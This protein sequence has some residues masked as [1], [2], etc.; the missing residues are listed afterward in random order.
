MGTISS[1]ASGRGSVDAADS[2][3]GDV[4]HDV[5]GFDNPGA[6]LTLDGDLIPLPRAP[7]RR[8]LREVHQPAALLPDGPS[9][10]DIN[11][12]ALGDCF[13]LAGLDRPR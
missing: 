7:P 9:V 10:F 4:I 5:D 13:F 12:G 11:Q 3:I 2:E 1:G 8:R 6:D